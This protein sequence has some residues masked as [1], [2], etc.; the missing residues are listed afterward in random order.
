MI[1]L[2]E[3]NNKEE[4]PKDHFDDLEVFLDDIWSKREKSSYYF[5]EEDN[6]VEQQRF[7][8]FL[9]KTKTIKSN[10]YVGVIHFEGKTINLLPKIFYKGENPKNHEVN[11]I[12]KHILWW[13]S[14][15][16]KLKFPNYLSGLHSEKADFFE[17]LIY[18]FSKY[19]R[20][21][22]NSSIYQK[23][24]DVNEELSFVKGRIDFNAYLRDN[25]SK[26]RNHKISCEYD[27]FQ[28]DNDFNR[29]VKYVSKLLVSIT[30][31]N[32]SRRY[33]NDILFILD[34]VE[35][36]NIS[37]DTMKRMKFNP[38]FSNFETIRDYCVLFL[39]NSV[40]FNY[41]N[42]LKLFAFLLP[43][44]YVFED[45]IFGFID[46]E[47]DE[48]KAKD[49][50]TSKYLA[51]NKKFQLKPDL[52]LEFDDRKLIGDTK[53]KIVYQDKNDLKKG[54][55]QSDL[56]QMIAYAIRFKVNEIVLFYPNT[57]NNQTPNNSELSIIDE[58]ADNEE[59][60]IKS[61]QLPIINFALFDNDYKSEHSLKLDFEKTKEELIKAIKLSLKK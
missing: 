58:L 16:R 29:C 51:E 60:Q 5:N 40:S 22:L 61:F 18:L 9:H 38:M 14:Y 59:I 3:Y 25:L 8:Q 50:D 24:T 42:D 19:T 45:F 34:E 2:F 11:A 1:N 32:Q 49:Q 4:F 53:Y 17:I 26:G 55:S 46:K 41:K 6:R 39:D 54:I 43:M 37:S 47:I 21:L 31:E 57:I 23:Y 7:I 30:K 35:D 56:Y 33:L 27:A 48:V 36:I 28:M 15:C 12:N 20:E 13:L 44:E 10:K 52:I